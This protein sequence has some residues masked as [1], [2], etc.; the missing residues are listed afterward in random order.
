MTRPQVA[1]AIS[2]CNNVI[3]WFSRESEAF[4]SSFWRESVYVSSILTFWLFVV[5][6]TQYQG[7]MGELIAFV[8]WWGQT[9]L[10]IWTCSSSKKYAFGGM[11]PRTICLS[12]LLSLLSMTQT[13]HLLCDFTWK[14]LNCRLICNNCYSKPSYLHTKPLDD[15]KGESK[16]TSR[17]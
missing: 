3:Q 4:G 9:P 6:L 10:N 13:P 8:I 5:L 7:G 11:F 15:I 16:N 1:H 14:P 2:K 12:S 17:I